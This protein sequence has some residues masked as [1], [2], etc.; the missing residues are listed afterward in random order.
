MI[1]IVYIVYMLLITKSSYQIS[2]Q[3]QKVE[4]ERNYDKKSHV[5]VRVCVFVVCVCVCVCACVRAC[6][7]ACVCACVR[8]CMRVCVRASLLE[9]QFLDESTKYS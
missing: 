1:A 6:V 5:Y 8:A 9:R 3:K 7:R 2:V 4:H